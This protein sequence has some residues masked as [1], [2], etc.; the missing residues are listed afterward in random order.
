MYGVDAGNIMDRSDEEF[1]ISSVH[2]LLAGAEI[3][4][5]DWEAELQTKTWVKAQ[6]RTASTLEGLADAAWQGP[7]GSSNSWFESGQKI[8]GFEQKGL[9][10]QYKL[11]MGLKI[12][13]IHQD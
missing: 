1:H 11:A 9:C 5:I 3:V 4:S 10:V 12:A 6:L 7:N 13:V 2:E 8:D